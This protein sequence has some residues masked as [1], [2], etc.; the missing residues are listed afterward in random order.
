MAKSGNGSAVVRVFISYS[1][2]S[3]E[4][5]ENMLNLAQ[6]LRKE[7]LD[8]WIDQFEETTPPLSWPQWMYDEIDKAKF[9]LVVITETYARRFMNRETPRRGLGVRWEGAIITSGL[10]HATDDEV[11]FIPVVVDASDSIYIPPPLSLTTRYNVGSIGDRELWPLLRHL[12]SKPTVIP[13]PTEHVVDLGTD[14]VAAESVE[15]SAEFRH[16]LEEAIVLITAGDKGR[17][18]A[19]LEKLLDGTPKEIAASA[20]YNLGLAWQEED[21]YTNSITAYQRAIELTPQSRTAELATNNLQLVLQIMNAHY[22]PEGP[23][24]AARKWLDFIH[25]SKIRRAWQRIHRDTRLI[26]AQAWI[27]ANEAHPNLQ[28]ADKEDLAAKL[29]HAKPT[30]HLSRAFLATQ[31]NEF[32]RAF[33]AYDRETWGAAEKPR[34]FGIA[35]ELVIFM[36][37]GGGEVLWQPGTE[38][39]AIQLLMQREATT[40]YVRGFSPELPVPGWPPTYRPLPGIEKMG[41]SRWNIED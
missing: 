20:A 12:L 39:P 33:Q 17:G 2:D 3:D 27:I 13:V 35:L 14:E 22:G 10:Y 41:E 5:R 28:G 25:D 9:V 26:L 6:V 7:G 37:T 36:M 38:A 32:Q 29:A 40:W 23:V 8:A 34:R 15:E 1:H 4:H 16:A 24:L 18:K 30:H 19:E 21:A 31:L 11:K